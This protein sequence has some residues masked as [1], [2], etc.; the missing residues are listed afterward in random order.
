ML[1]EMQI[2]KQFNKSKT[3]SCNLFLKKLFSQILKCLFNIKIYIFFKLSQLLT[4][5]LTTSVASGSF[6]ES[7]S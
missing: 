7:F 3:K 1:V 2:G 6:S 5:K 4:S